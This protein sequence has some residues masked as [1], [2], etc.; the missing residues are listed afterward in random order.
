MDDTIIKYKLL[1]YIS[2]VTWI[3]KNLENIAIGRDR[4]AIPFYLFI[5]VLFLIFPRILVGL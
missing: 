2:N 4:V 1:T 3:K 5:F